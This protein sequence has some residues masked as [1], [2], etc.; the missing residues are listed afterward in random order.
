VPFWAC[1]SRDGQAVAVRL[2]YASDKARR[3]RAGAWMDQLSDRRCCSGCG[4]WLARASVTCL[5][6]GRRVGSLPE[7][8]PYCVTCAEAVTSGSL[9]GLR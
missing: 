8:I 7:A 4:T 6:S 1:E 3:L 5:A 2:G 9:P